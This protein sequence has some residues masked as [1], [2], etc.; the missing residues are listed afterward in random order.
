MNPDP[1]SN[2]PNAA[3]LSDAT[4]QQARANAELSQIQVA[5][6][7]LALS[8]SATTQYAALVVKAGRKVDPWRRLKSGPPW[9][10]GRSDLGG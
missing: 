8:T 3:A 6:A 10:T 9:G 4:L 1:A 5:Q 7:K 2:D